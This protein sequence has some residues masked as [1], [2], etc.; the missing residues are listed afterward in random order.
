MESETVQDA[1]AGSLRVVHFY[2]AI[3]FGF[4]SSY[5]M[6]NNAAALVREA[7]K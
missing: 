3:A 7:L 2:E 6:A 1:S 4:Q 5:G